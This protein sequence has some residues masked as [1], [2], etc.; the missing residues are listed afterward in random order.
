MS[1]V[2][3]DRDL[4]AQLV[5]CIVMGPGDGDQV[6]IGDLAGVLGNQPQG[7]GGAVGVRVGQQLA[8]DGGGGLQPLA[9]GAG[10]GVETGVVD[11]DRGGGSDGG[12]E[13]FVLGAECSLGALGQVEV[14]EDLVADADGHTEEAVHRG[15]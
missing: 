10:G 2:D 9:A 11:R 14:A 12:G 5:A 6:C 1:G 3:A 8:G 13:L 15:V 4:D 7:V